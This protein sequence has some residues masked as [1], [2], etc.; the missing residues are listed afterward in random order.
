[1][2]NHASIEGFLVIEEWSASVVKRLES[3]TRKL[4]DKGPVLRAI[5]YWA[6]LQFKK[7]ISE[8][9]SPSG[10]PFAPLKKARG[11]GHNPSSKPL[12]DT[13]A[14]F[15]DIQFEEDIAD[16]SVAVGN[17]SSIPYALFQNDGTRSIPAREYLGI[18]EDK[19]SPVLEAAARMIVFDEEDQFLKVSFG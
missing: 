16:S 10:R 12:F 18:P 3:I 19:L 4:N 7:N 14:L 11:K 13:G 6:A 2:T 1:M 5:G 8:S 9:H 17:S 15:D